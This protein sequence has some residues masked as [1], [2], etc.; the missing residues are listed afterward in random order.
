ML[1]RG[2]LRHEL[3]G[4][5]SEAVAGDRASDHPGCEGIKPGWV[6]VNFNYFI[7]DTVFT[8][9]LEAVRLVARHG[10]RLLGDYDFDPTTGRWTHGAR[11]GRAP[12][13]WP[14]WVSRVGG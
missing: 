11:T 10:W 14:K 9:L 7:S 13:C 8:Y 12:R 6:R 4:I 1:V 3:L 2:S 5:D